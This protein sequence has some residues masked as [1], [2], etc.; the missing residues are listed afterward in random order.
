[1]TLETIRNVQGNLLNSEMCVCGVWC[2]V[3]MVYMVCGVC[4]VWCVVCVCVCV[5]A[6]VDRDFFQV[7]IN[8]ALLHSLAVGCVELCRP[9][10]ALRNAVG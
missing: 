8:E 9:L 3:Y 10:I 1:M 6:C 7:L 5:R 4:G 2:V